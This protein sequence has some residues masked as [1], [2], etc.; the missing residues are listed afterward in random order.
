VWHPAPVIPAVRRQRQEDPRS[1]QSKLQVETLPQ[2][3]LINES[4]E[5]VY[6]THVSG[7]IKCY[8]HN[9]SGKSY[10]LHHNMVEKLKGK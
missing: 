5:K 7:V 2:K 8:A 6:F 1:G 4:K 9:V 3:T 10:C